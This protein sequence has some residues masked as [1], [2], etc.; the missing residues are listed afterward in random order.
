M[1]ADGNINSDVVR[2]NLREGI[3]DETKLNEKTRECVEFEGT[4]AEM[5]YNMLTCVE[6][7]LTPEVYA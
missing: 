1:D 6:Q 7:V 2:K 5:A 3:E 4:P